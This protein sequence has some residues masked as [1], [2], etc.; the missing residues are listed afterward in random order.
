[1]AVKLV[2]ERIDM[3]ETTI[4][5]GELVVTTILDWHE[6]D[7]SPVDDKIDELTKKAIAA[8]K[9]GARAP[10]SL[11]TPSVWP[12]QDPRRLSSCLYLCNLLGI[13]YTERE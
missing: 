3:N 6:F 4:T 5:G 10:P 8:T 9:R 13:A 12:S 2:V 11:A 1:M 7:A